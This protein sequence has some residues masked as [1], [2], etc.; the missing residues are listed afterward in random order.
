MAFEGLLRLAQKRL[1]IEALK[2]M[3]WSSRSTQPSGSLAPGKGDSSIHHHLK[4]QRNA[5]CLQGG[6]A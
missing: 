5:P 1:G 4:A 3:C 2:S 6:L